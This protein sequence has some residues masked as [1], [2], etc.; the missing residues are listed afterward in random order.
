[1]AQSTCAEC[2]ER[3][4]PRRTDQAYCSKLCKARA[5]GKRQREGAATLTCS[6][7]GCKA[8]PIAG[9]RRGLCSTHY[10][11]LRS[12]GDVGS[13][14]LERGGRFGIQPCSV[15]GCER[16]YYAKDLCALHYNRL[17]RTG[18]VGAPSTTK[19]PHGAGTIAIVNGYR[20]LQWYK[21]GKRIAVSEHRQVMEQ[22]LGRP[23]EPFENVHHK[24]G[25][26]ADN[27]PGNLELWVKPQPSGQ[28]PEDLV[29]W[30]IEHYRDL[31]IAELNKP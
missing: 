11:R 20:R 8:R 17:Q 5:R 24:N 3:F 29:A 26:R 23:L 16:L 1:M 25:R 18:A 28:R 19:R 10:R 2:G 30:V 15:P 6:V 21:N 13:A 12:R 31:V 14:E 7:E 4:D 9:L 27:R 22:V